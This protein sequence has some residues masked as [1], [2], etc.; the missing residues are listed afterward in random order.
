MPYGLLAQQTILALAGTALLYWSKP[1]ALG[2]N[3]WSGN[4]HRKFPTL[5]HL[6][7]RQ[8][9]GTELNYRI[10]LLCFRITGALLLTAGIILDAG[11]FWVL[12]I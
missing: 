2:L 6:L 5:N 4:Q 7:G 11:V 3:A 9:V 12:H 1:L 8:N 10:A